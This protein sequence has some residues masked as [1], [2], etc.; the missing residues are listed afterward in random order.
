MSP[1]PEHRHVVVTGAMGVGK[2]TTAEA[3]ARRLAR[4]RRD[5]DDD[6]EALFGVS[7]A[8]LA[9][10]VGVD[11]LHRLESAVLLGAL[12]DERPSIIAAAGWVVEDPRCREA[13]A[14]RA[15]AVVLDAPAEA[16]AARISTGDHRRPMDRS[17][18]ESLLARRE[19]LFDA[20]ADLRLDATSPTPDLVTAILDHLGQ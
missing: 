15:T 17:E 13:L 10:R 12:A 9:A 1:A 14:R 11:E 2:T 19:P 6:I 3:L 7:G 20:V 4:P 8:E 16:L 18:L 5:S